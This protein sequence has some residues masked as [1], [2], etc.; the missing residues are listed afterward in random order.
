MFDYAGGLL[1]DPAPLP[2]RQ[3]DGGREVEVAWVWGSGMAVRREVFRRVGGF[4]E[5]FFMYY[6]DLDWCWRVRKAGW[7]VV[8]YPDLWVRHFV[9]RSTAKVPPA[10]TTDRLAQGELVLRRR[11]MSPHRYRNF[12]IARFFYSLRG[13]MFYRL[14]LA[15]A[16]CERFHTKYFR[17]LA[18]VRQIL[19]MSGAA[20]AVQRHASR[21]TALRG[22][23][24][25][26]T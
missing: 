18:N 20:R 25:N 23:P 10:V 26:Q 8:C 17:Y 15:L 5:T 4:D 3:G 12:L 24:R 1:P 2:P 19:L 16:P 6:E 9:R 21:L 11:H 7:K 22:E 13:I 14:M